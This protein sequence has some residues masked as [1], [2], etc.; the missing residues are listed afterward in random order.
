MKKIHE[1]FDWTVDIDEYGESNFED[2]PTLVLFIINEE[3]GEPINSVGGVDVGYW[4]SDHGNI[5]IDPE[6]EPYLIDLVNAYI[7]DALGEAA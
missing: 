1:G 4:I 2:Q 3:T 6:H 7:E 5:H